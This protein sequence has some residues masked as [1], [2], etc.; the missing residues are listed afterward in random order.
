MSSK[1]ED[2]TIEINGEVFEL[3]RKVF[4]LFILIS[5]ERDEYFNAIEKLLKKHPHE[6]DIEKIILARRKGLN[7][8]LN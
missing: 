8:K 6:K 3:P 1:K 2:L 5:K 7:Q 4:D